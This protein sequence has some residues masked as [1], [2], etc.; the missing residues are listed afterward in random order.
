MDIDAF[1][2]AARALREEFRSRGEFTTCDFRAALAGLLKTAPSNVVTAVAERIDEESVF[3][4][5]DPKDRFGLLGEAMLD[6]TRRIAKAR[7][8][9]GQAEESIAYMERLM[10]AR[11]ARMN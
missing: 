7:Q 11:A 2:P 3:A 10:R 8:T 9:L 6:R 1:L 5:P 4:P